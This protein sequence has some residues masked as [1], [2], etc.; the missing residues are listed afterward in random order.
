MSSKLMKT[1][2]RTGETTQELITIT[3]IRIQNDIN[4][5]QRYK[6]AVWVHDH[7]WTP[8]LKGYRTTKYG[9]YILHSVYNLDTQIESF[10]IA[11]ETAVRV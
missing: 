11:F 4:G 9:E 10:I 7:Q 1:A 3:A 2:I 8:K 6:L 5:N